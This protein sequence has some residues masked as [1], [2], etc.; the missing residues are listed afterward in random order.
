[1][2]RGRDVCQR[3]AARIE[4]WLEGERDQIVLWVPVA[5]GAGVL[6]WF[7][8]PDSARWCGFLAA[9]AAL[10]LAAALAPRGGRLPRMVGIGA[11]LAAAGCLLAWTRAEWVAAPVLARPAIVRFDA[12]VER[13][14]SLVA[15]DLVRLTLAPV[16]RGDLPPRVRVNVEAA[17][18]GAGIVAGSRI[19][20]RARLMPPPGPAVPGAYDFA[21]AA[22]FDGLG[23]VGRAL[24]PP[25][26]VVPSPAA[27]PGLRAALTAHILDRLP[28]SAGG[29]AAALA[30]GDEGAIAAE[31][32]EAMRRSGLAHLLSVS[33]LHV[34]A[35][36]AAAMTI[37]LRLLVF[38]PGLALR[39]RLP[40]VA[41]LAGA[42]AAIGYTWLTGGQVPTL[43][44]CVAALL[45][46]LALVLGREAMTLRLVAAGAVVVLL[47]APASLVGASFQLSFAAVAAIVALHES[48][49]IERWFAPRDEG[50]LA[51]WARALGGLLVTGI[52]VELALTPIALFHFHRSGL[53][54]SVANLVA[55]PLTTF[56]IMPVEALALLLDLLGLG[57]PLWWV[58]G[59]ALALLLGLAHLVAAA[60]GASASLPAM[61]GGAFALTIAGG[62]WLALW[63][64]RLRL[65]GAVPILAGA[66]WAVATPPP[67][68]IITGDGRHVAL[69]AADGSVYLLRERAGDYVR[70]MLGESAGSPPPFDALDA[71]DPLPEARCSPDLC[72]VDIVRP[73]GHW[74]VVATRSPY[75]I[76]REQLLPLCAGT[77]IVVSDRALPRGCVPRWLRLD[78]P[79][80]ARTGGVAIRFPAR[81]ATVRT[82]GDHPW[83]HPLRVLPAEAAAPARIHRPAPPQPQ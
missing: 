70:T 64:T 58:A 36:T 42:A 22:W 54:G 53:Y 59:R 80:L 18:I 14:E 26:L 81:L 60:P 8:L 77:D 34:S 15:R 76:A 20:L 73:D 7:V 25:V 68:L 82:G 45:V 23:A 40:L 47:I 79:L 78:R 44:S 16:G 2:G 55:I 74:R 62:L 3:A 39:I 9:M 46:L 72:V 83:E 41:A 37:A 32:A 57:A 17:D 52:V 51:G 48:P 67:D 33:G 13:V 65:L 19:A 35:V 30:T 6:A 28:G 69:R 61:P 24:D 1:M 49:R 29:I 27:G 12:R 21:R 56:V 31:D 38:V 4:H 5:L 66:L 71:F 63:R 43:R 11:L 75:P 10:A 50:R